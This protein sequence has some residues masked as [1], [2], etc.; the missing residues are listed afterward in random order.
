[1]AKI[2]VLI[3]ILLSGKRGLLVSFISFF[4]K[5][6]TSYILIISFSIIIIIYSLTPTKY[7]NTIKSIGSLPLLEVIGP[8]GKEIIEVCNLLDSSPIALIFGF[9]SGFYYMITDS[10][11]ILQITHNV[12][13]TPLSLI[14]SYGLIYTIIF[15]IYIINIIRMK[16][17][18][19]VF[20]LYLILS[21]LYSFTAYSLFI[22]F[23]FLIA[24]CGLK[25]NVRNKLYS[26]S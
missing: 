17:Q 8:R 14:S 20:K 15:Y 16:S 23:L 21:L 13:F 18:L 24:I 22:D 12:H 5:L 1:M 26:I 3:D 25:N 19:V 11:N 4:S 10:N 6:K 2:T 9:G 7:I